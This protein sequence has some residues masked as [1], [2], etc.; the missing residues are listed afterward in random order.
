MAS[1]FL[2]SSNRLRMTQKSSQRTKLKVLD[3]TTDNE[4]FPTSSRLKTKNL[5]QLSPPQKDPDKG[6]TIP[7]LTASLVKSIVGSG[8]L[9]LPA[10]VSTLGNSPDVVLPALVIIAVIGGITAYFFSL[11]GRVCSW[12]GATSYRDAWERT[13]GPESSQSVA[14]VVTLKTA[15]SCLAYSM[16]LAD[17]FQALGIA[18]GLVDITRTEALGGV[19]VFALLPLCLLQDLKAL[20]PF[21]FLGLLGMGFASAAICIRSV[22]GSYA[23]GGTF[24]GDIPANLQPAFGDSGPDV[25]GIVLACTLATAFVAHYNAPRFH[26]ELQ[27][28]T[29]QRFNLVTL[30]S[31]AI[32]AVLSMVVAVQ[33]F[34]TFGSHSSGL[35]LNNYSP[36]D[37]L[38]TA[39]RATVASSL[40]FS[41]PLPF[42]GFRDGMLDALSISGKDRTDTPL[43]NALSVGLL[44]TVTLAA[45]SIQDLALVLSIGG[46]SLSTIVASVFPA[47]MYRAAVNKSSN[48]ARQ[49]LDVNL[50]LVLM[51]ICVAIGGTGVFLALEKAIQ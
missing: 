29:E 47:L 3:K 35:I 13:V 30:I 27:D 21:S 31:Y 2:K 8:I 34:L 1:S 40:L 41:Y 48:D 49:A 38:F 15:I 37:P 14:I 18:A 6:G 12:T 23:D 25:Q 16:I 43:L 32:A 9:A 4:D 46:G 50:A 5:E 45:D 7:Q 20:T 36:Y 51:W 39:S 10:G 33:G 42:V 19:T 26:A 24:L 22:D 44:A 28:N 11:I 17:S